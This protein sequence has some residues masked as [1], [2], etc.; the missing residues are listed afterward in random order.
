MPTDIRAAIAAR[1][2]GVDL[3]D[4]RAVWAVLGADWAHGSGGG[5]F[6]I[7][8]AAWVVP[9]YGGIRG[10]ADGVAVQTWSSLLDALCA[11]AAVVPGLAEG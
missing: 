8:S 5:L 9:T 2:A 1:L 4:S 6:H 7:P 11:I 10:S 3:R